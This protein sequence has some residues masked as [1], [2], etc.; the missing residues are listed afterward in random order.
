[1]AVYIN[2]NE[3]QILRRLK[4]KIWTIFN[5]MQTASNGAH[6]NAYITALKLSYITKRELLLVIHS[7]A[8]Q[9]LSLVTGIKFTLI[10]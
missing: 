8:V 1:M 6:A 10:C 2:Y 3:R 9:S 7:K 4:L 5:T